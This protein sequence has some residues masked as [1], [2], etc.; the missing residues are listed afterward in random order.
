[1]LKGLQALHSQVRRSMTNSVRRWLMCL[2]PNSA[3]N[4]C[5]CCATLMR[6]MTSQDY[7]PCWSSEM[8]R[9]CGVGDRQRDMLHTWM[10]NAL[11]HYAC[12][13]GDPER[14]GRHTLEPVMGVL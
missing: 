14:K 10:M 12:R 7:R 8:M 13:K 11:C 1:M 2:G 3:C 5:G 6:W 9:R 4:W